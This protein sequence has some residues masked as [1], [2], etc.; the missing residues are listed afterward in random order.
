MCHCISICRYLGA[1]ALFTWLVAGSAVGWE[2]EA[3]RVTTIDTFSS[4][5]FTTVTFQEPFPVPPV[6]VPLATDQGGDPAAL[7]IQNVTNTG[8]ELTVVEPTGNDGPHVS[9]TIDYLAAEEGIHTLP[10]GETVIVGRHTTDSVQASNVLG[11]VEAFDTVSFGASLAQPAAL[12]AAIQTMNSETGT[13]PGGPSIP[14]LTIASRN[15]TQ[16]DVQLALERSE[17]APGTVS[18]ETI[19]YIAFPSASAGDFIALGGSTISWS[20]LVSNDVFVGFDDPC[21]T[22]VF[23]PTPFPDPRVIATKATRDGAD[24]GWLRRC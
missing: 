16:T 18:P 17:V 9:M 24:G 23:S 21:N 13:P 19:G 20:A 1:S 8:F 15:A 7:R 6:V 12:I 10:T 5:A 4:T 2:L 22:Q 3:G 14:W 11:L